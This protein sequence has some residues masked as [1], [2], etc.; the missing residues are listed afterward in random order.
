MASAE[1]DQATRSAI[2]KAFTLIPEG[3]TPS[4]FNNQFLASNSTSAPHILAA[5]SA[6]L[7]LEKSEVENILNKLLDSRVSPT[8]SGLSSAIEILRRSGASAESVAAFKS[9][10]RE[11]L[12]LAWIFA[13]EPEKSERNLSEEGDRMAVNGEKSDV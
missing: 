6:S 3:T 4:D 12:P 13:S 7:E 5:A 9:K 8:V 11:R 10:C 1:L 2:E